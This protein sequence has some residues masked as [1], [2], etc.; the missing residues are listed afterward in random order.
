MP[1]KGK[2]MTI[3]KDFLDADFRAHRPSHMGFQYTPDFNLRRHEIV[4]PR[5]KIQNKHVLDIGCFN[6][7]TADWCLNNGVSSYTGIEISDD[8]YNTAFDLLNKHHHGQAWKIFK[9]GVEKYLETCTQQFDLIIAWGLHN[10]VYDHVWLMKQFAKKGQQ[11]LIAGRHPMAM[12]QGIADILTKDQLHELE[13]NIPYQEW[14][15][16]D[17][18]TFLYKNNTSI[19]CTGS[20]SSM[21]A[22]SLT[23]ELEGF[24]SSTDAYQCLKKEFPERFGFYTAS[25]RQGFFVLEFSR[26]KDAVKHRTYDQ[27]HES[28][29]VD[30]KNLI[31]WNEFN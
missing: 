27:M 31:D 14:H 4:L 25:H 22:L 1:N 29:T 2:P 30:K 23:M 6:G 3:H 10:Y 20:N 15:H 21:A 13:F 17:V 7:L 24:K 28:T 19:R 18:M 5:N 12:W 9:V 16:G 8:F 26:D 11:I